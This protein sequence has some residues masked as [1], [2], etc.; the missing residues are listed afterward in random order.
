LG[1]WSAIERFPSATRD[2]VGVEEFRLM[3]E[4]GKILFFVKKNSLLLVSGDA[5]G[6]LVISRAGWCSE[7]RRR[8]WRL[9]LS[10][11][12]R[13]GAGSRSGAGAG[14]ILPTRSTPR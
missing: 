6:D 2:P 4:V 3:L 1:T 5:S 11:R 9:H 13:R 8:P 14:Q 10:S 7:G 12:R